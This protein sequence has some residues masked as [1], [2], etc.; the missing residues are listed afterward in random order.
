MSAF[1]RSGHICLLPTVPGRGADG[2]GRAG[3]QWP[4]T[5]LDVP[6]HRLRDAE[7]DVVILQRPTE[8][9]M[10]EEWTGRR[11][12]RDVPAIYVEHNAPTGHAAGSLHVLAGQDVIPIV[13]VTEFNRLMWDCGHA[14]SSVIEHGVVDPGYLYTGV[15]NRVATMINEPVRR[16]RIV[17]TDLLATVAQEVEV[18]IYG[19]DTA[20]LSGANGIVGVKQHGDLPLE[21]VHI[22]IAQ[23]RIYLHTSRWTSLGLSLLEAMFLGM[24]VIAVASTAAATIP[25]DVAAVSCNIDELTCWA[26]QLVNEPTLA[27]SRGRAAREWAIHRYGLDRFLEDW[28]AAL[29]AVSRGRLAY[30]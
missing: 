9:A 15:L 4:A 27:R 28:D 16:S 1:I 14:P 12:G 5:A 8:I 18:D 3:R 22:Q 25:A 24:P 19:I 10:V 2:R 11:P 17:G 23:R 30:Q 13:H 26:A 21:S 7:F 6:F 29:A 20:A